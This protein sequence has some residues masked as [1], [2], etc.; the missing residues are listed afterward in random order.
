MNAFEKLLVKLVDAKIAFAVIGG[1]ACAF[2]GWTRSTL[3][4]DI[5]LKYDKQNVK[6]LLEILSDWGDA[7]QM[8]YPKMIL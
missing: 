4:V 2:N 6:L 7:P 3:D 1:F 5:L 8:N